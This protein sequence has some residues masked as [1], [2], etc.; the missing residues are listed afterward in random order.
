MLSL[1]AGHVIAQAPSN[2]R[3]L[4]E[5]DHAIVLEYTP[6][7]VVEKLAGNGAQARVF[8]RDGSDDEYDVATGQSLPSRRI[9]LLFPT[10]HYTVHIAGLES[11]VVQSVQPV[12]KRIGARAQTAALKGRTTIPRAEII[13]VAPGPALTRA[14]LVLRPAEVVGATSLRVYS[15]IVVEVDFDPWPRN[16]LKASMALTRRSPKPGSVASRVSVKKTLTDSPLAQGDWYRMDVQQTGIYKLDMSFFKSAKI[17]TAVFSSIRSIRVFGNGGQVLPED[18]NAARPGDLQEVPCL[19]VDNNGNG[20]FDADDYILFYGIGL[21]EWSYDPGQRQFSHYIHPYSET[22]EYF[23]TYGGAPGKGMD[24]VVSLKNPAPFVPTDFEEMLFT[25]QEKFNLL[26]SGRRWLGQSFDDLSPSAVYTTLLNGLVATKPVNYR[27][28]VLSRSSTN[29]EFLVYENGNLLGS[30]V[31]LGTVDVDPNDDE[32]YYAFDPGVVST[33]GSGVIPGNRSLLKFE[34]NTTNDA[35]MG[36]LDWFEIHYRRTFDAVNDVLLFFGPD[37]SATAE[38]DL[39]NFSSRNTRIFDVTNPASPRQVTQ[40]KFDDVKASVC[41]FQAIQSAG[42]PHRYLAVGETGYL[43]PA[44]VVQVANTNLHGQTQPYDFIIISPQEF[45]ADA[46]RLQSFRQQADTL[47]TVVVDVANIFN[48]FA[49]GIPDPTAIRDFL[50]YTQTNWAVAP[51]YVL[52]FGNGSYDYKNIVSSARNWISAYETAESINQIL[53]YTTDD[54]FAKLNPGDDR[55]SLSIGRLPARSEQDAATMVDKV[56]SYETT[57]P[58]DPWRNTITFVSDDGLTSTGDDGDVFTSSSEDLA[59][60]HTPASFDKQKIYIVEYPTINS[61]AGRRKPLANQAII[62]AFNRGTLLMNYIGH[63]NQLLW[64]HEYIFTRDESLP[65]LVNKDMLTFVIGATCNFAAFDDPNQVSAGEQIVTMGQGG[66]IGIMTAVRQV[67]ELD[68]AYFNYTF[69][70]SLFQAGPHGYDWRMGD[71]MYQTKQ[72][73]YSGTFDNDLKYVLLC[74]PTVRFAV[75][76]AQ[77]TVDTVNGL[78]TVSLSTLRSLGVAAVSG[79]ISHP[80]GQPWTN[81]N[82]SGL[83]ELFDPKQVESV[84]IW[85]GFT[86]VM[87]GS[88]LYRGAVSVKNG[89]FHATIPVPKDVTYGGQSRIEMYAS[90]DS[91]DAVGFTENVTINGTDTAAV[92]DTTGPSIAIYFDDLSFRSGDIVRPTTTL[93]VKLDDASGINTSTVGVGHRLQALLTNPDQ[94][95]DLTDFYRGDLD[96]YRSGQVSYPFSDLTEGKHVA[97]VQAWDVRNN[98]STAQVEF[99][100]RSAGPVL[101]ENV[102]NVPNPFSRS[103]V[104]TFQRNATDPIDVQIKIYSV[105]GRL[106]RDFSTYGVSDRFVQVPWDGRDQ[107]GNELANGVYF[108]R[109]VARSSDGSGRAESIGK[110]AVMR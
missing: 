40:V 7:V 108:Y 107:D 86:F 78:S 50:K 41:S 104:F 65:Q 57:A 29:D 6:H 33:S 74:D 64:A 101:M 2:V 55:I 14:T 1:F 9:P 32:D 71:V 51:Q 100:V 34:F 72:E 76:R 63:G 110:L 53:T 77:A 97:T 60:L 36:W 11:H 23:F 3:I 70:D 15:R 42:S 16:G 4:S 80:G 68:N 89:T 84:P 82:G 26:S 91:S 43:Q 5:N 105:A 62:D 83:V 79:T 69:F 75:P 103:T 102:V 67:Y 48:E 17:P 37:T 30:P 59:E 73:H 81:F 109:I 27:F 46:Q 39:T 45:L 18:V 92:V 106:L 93:I 35:A 28:D 54:Y 25:E 52:L 44:N 49:G 61:A 66:A 8:V 31:Q 94:T 19:R 87:S 58:H 22:N 95:I 47:R 10:S 90:G 85:P 13:D 88:V 56:I 24:S 20:V 21:R 99:E 96:T 12:S 98:G 38:F